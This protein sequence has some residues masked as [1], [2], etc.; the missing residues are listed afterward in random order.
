MLTQ[1]SFGLEIRQ[2][3]L[4]GEAILF[5]GE[6]GVEIQKLIE[7]KFLDNSELK[8]EEVGKLVNIFIEQAITTYF[9]KFKSPP[10]HMPTWKLRWY[11]WRNLM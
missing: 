11:Y 2:L 4:S 3:D 1:F 7:D 6:K 8:P 10:W 9:L 5:R